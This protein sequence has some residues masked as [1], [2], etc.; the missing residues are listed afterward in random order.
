VQSATSGHPLASACRDLTC[1][2][3]GVYLHDARISPFYSQ[4]LR[5]KSV[6]QVLKEKLTSMELKLHKQGG[7][8]SEEK[9]QGRSLFGMRRALGLSGGS[10]GEVSAQKNASLVDDTVT[11]EVD[12]SAGDG[13]AG[14]DGDR[15]QV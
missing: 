7:G 8:Q 11:G 15:R 10:K 5:L 12:V 3:R 9:K 14:G 6:V 13:E 4:V 2:T 1:A